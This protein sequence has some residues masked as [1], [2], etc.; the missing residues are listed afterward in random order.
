MD[1]IKQMQAKMQQEEVSTKQGDAAQR[2]VK[3]LKMDHGTCSRRVRLH[4]VTIL[5][6][7]K[8]MGYLHAKEY[9]LDLYMK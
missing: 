3:K 9:Q 6:P 2:I 7:V 5:K 1:K 4:A 8:A